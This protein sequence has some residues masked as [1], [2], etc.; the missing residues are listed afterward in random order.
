MICFCYIRRND[1]LLS[2]KGGFRSSRYVVQ[3]SVLAAMGLLCM[4]PSV[5]VRPAAVY[6]IWPVQKLPEVEY[7]NLPSR[8]LAC[9]AILVCLFA[10]SFHF[11][12]HGVYT[13]VREGCWIIIIFM[14]S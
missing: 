9:S 14:Y 3:G 12:F 4:L 5:P 7:S 6:F 2:S 11:L 8:N 1:L 10:G 13:Y